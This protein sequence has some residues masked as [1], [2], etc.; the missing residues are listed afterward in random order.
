MRQDVL[1]HQIRSIVRVER[2][3]DQVVVLVHVLGVLVFIALRQIL[4]KQPL[5]VILINRLPR[6]YRKSL[7]HPSS[8][9]LLGTLT[10]CLSGNVLVQCLPVGLSLAEAGS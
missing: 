6:L 5:L 10:T 1:E 7:V 8:C 4:T 3:T 9:R 2:V